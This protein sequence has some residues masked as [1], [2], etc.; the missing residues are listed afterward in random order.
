MKLYL[1]LTDEIE[2]KI[3]MVFFCSGVA[4]ARG[5]EFSGVDTWYPK[6]NSNAL[7]QISLTQVAMQFVCITP[8]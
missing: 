4:E 3:E 5:E 1:H 8:W 6:L 2:Y 7:M